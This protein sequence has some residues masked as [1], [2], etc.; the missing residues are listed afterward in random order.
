MQT[1]YAAFRVIGGERHGNKLR[2]HGKRS[3]KPSVTPQAL[4]ELVRD[5][6]EVAC[7]RNGRE[8][9]SQSEQ[10]EG[11]HRKLSALMTGRKLADPRIGLRDDRLPALRLP[12]GVWDGFLPDGRQSEAEGR[13]LPGEAL[14]GGVPLLQFL[15]ITTSTSRWALLSLGSSSGGVVTA[16]A[17]SPRPAEP[18][19]LHQLT[20]HASSA[21]LAWR[22]ASSRVSR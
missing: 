16:Q 22:R 8:C 2:R 12:H 6:Q 21:G 5:E 7:A 19:V 14:P 9:V 18:L 4:N 10:L 13:L 17:K 15:S 11:V 20:Q 3:G 1:P